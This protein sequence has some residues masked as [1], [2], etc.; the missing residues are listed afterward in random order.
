MEQPQHNY[1]GFVTEGNK[2]QET[3]DLDIK[4]IAKLVRADIKATVKANNLPQGKY[5][6][7]ISRYAGG[8]SMSVYVSDTQ[9]IIDNPEYNYMTHPGSER[10]TPEAQAMRKTV[11][12]IANAYNFDDCDS[13]T[14]YFHVNYYVHVSI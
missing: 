8:Q 13:M 14:D 7:T 12:E 5:S 6:V 11:Q 9:L 2:Y 4:D 3:K 1:S 10:Y